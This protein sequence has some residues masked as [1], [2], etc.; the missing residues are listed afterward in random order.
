MYSW[1]ES[2]SNG[3]LGLPPGIEASVVPAI[4]LCL[5]RSLAMQ[6]ACQ[7]WG[8]EFA[9]PMCLHEAVRTRITLTF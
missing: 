7:S 6:K 5:Q 1:D 9:I 4:L 8:T 2:H 3:F